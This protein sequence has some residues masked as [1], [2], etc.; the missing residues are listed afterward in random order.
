MNAHNAFP[1]SEDVALT[2][3]RR[4]LTPPSGSEKRARS[5]LRIIAEIRHVFRWK[6]EVPDPQA[7]EN[8]E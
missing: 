6:T 7:S 1:P 4:F 2:F 8:F 3:R 5:R